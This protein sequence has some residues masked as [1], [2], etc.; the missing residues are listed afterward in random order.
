MSGKW[1]EL[2]KEI[3]PGVTQVAVLREHTPAGVG[4]FAAIQA[5]APSL[6]VEVRP[7]NLQNAAEIERDL[8]SFA[9]VSNAGLIVASSTTALVNR[10]L[11]IALAMRHKSPAVYAQR[12]FVVAGGLMSYAADFSVQF[13][14][15]AGYVDRILKG[16]KPADLPVQAPTKYALV[17]NLKTAKTLG[18]ELPASV[19]A[20]ADEVIE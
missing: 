13:R 10:N 16:E 3:T 6:G 14:N 2:L 5:V 15:A 17:I 20:R 7:I 1:L 8:V 19:L 18:L 9:R 4:Q 11:I 12:E